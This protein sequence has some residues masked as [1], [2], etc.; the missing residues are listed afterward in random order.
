[1]A[2]AAAEEAIWRGILMEFLEGMLGKGYW[3]PLVQAASFGAIQIGGF[4][5]GWSGVG[6]SSV[7]GLMLGCIRQRSNARSPSGFEFG[8][9]LSS[10]KEIIYA[11]R[12]I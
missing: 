12:K 10:M 2:N 4:P 5:Q 8:E 1:M 9:P 7:C 3:A 11:T 6:L